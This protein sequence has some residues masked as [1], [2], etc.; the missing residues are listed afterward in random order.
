MAEKWKDIK[1]YEG[2]Y[3]V[4]NHGR[5]KGLKRNVLLKPILSKK[6][7]GYYRACLY[8]QGVQNLSSIHRL[9]AECFITNPNNYPIIMHLD[10]DPKNNHV[11]NLKWGT[12]KMNTDDMVS[13]MRAANGSKC[14]RS[15]LV[16]L[17]VLMIRKLKRNGIKTRDIANRFNVH[18]DTVNLI[19]RRKTW[20][21]I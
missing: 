6:K 16:E 2:L 19:A 14:A 1:G 20:K 11:D 5:V 7:Y 3:A 9:V 4:S 18:L 12:N 8:L 21:H 13:K 17:E 10:D 15:K